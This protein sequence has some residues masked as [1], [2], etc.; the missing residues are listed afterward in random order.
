MFGILIIT[1]QQQVTSITHHQGMMVAQDSAGL[2]GE[3]LVNL[4]NCRIHEEA[5]LAA[6]R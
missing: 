3:Q 1:G 4:G 6:G 5:G 2:M